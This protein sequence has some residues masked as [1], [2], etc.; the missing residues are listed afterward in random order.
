MDSGDFKL[1]SVEY[2][3][4][5]VQNIFDAFRSYP[6]QIV[7]RAVRNHRQYWYENL[8]TPKYAEEWK[9]IVRKGISSDYEVSNWGRVR[10]MNSNNICV[11]DF[12]HPYLRVLIRL[13]SRKRQLVVHRLV[14]EAFKGPIPVGWDVHHKDSDK[15]NARADNLDIVKKSQHMRDAY[16]TGERKPKGKRKRQ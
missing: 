9:S 12:G 4:I 14:V 6:P 8:P 1:M 16:K 7:E 11:P 13:E 2:V 5:F 10:D 15:W 3:D